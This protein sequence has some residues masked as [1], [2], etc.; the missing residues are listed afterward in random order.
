VT[1][2]G[3]EARRA[4]ASLLAVI[5]GSV[6]VCAQ[7]QSTTLPWLDAPEAIANYIRTAPVEKIEDLPV[8]VTRPNRAIL[9]AGGPVSSVVLKNLQPGRKNGFWESYKSEVAAYELDRILELNMVPPTVERRV[10]GNLMSA[11]MYV[12][13]CVWLKEL[14]GQEPPNVKDWNRQVHRQRVFDNLINNI[15]RNAGNLL[16]YRNPDWHLVLIDHSR[17]FTRTKKFIFEMKQIDQPL[18]DRLK[19]LDR[20]TL[21]ARLGKMIVDGPGSI[22]ERR[23]AIVAH[24]EKLASVK[25]EAAVFIP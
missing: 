3:A 15:D 10:N 21:E 18:F 9:A 16:V 8:G 11:Q 25:G 19:A 13:R 4:K 17:C 23:D 22:L 14:K 24:F 20:A 1:S 5:L 2:L 6:V 7:Q 12:D